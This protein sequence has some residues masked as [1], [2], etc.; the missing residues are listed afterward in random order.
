MPHLGRRSRHR[1]SHGT[2]GFQTQHT[3]FN[4]NSMV[5]TL[6]VPGRSNQQQSQRRLHQAVA[7]LSYQHFSRYHYPLYSQRWCLLLQGKGSGLYKLQHFH[8]IRTYLPVVAKAFIRP[9]PSHP[10]AL[11]TLLQF[12]PR[13]LSS[14]GRGPELTRR[15]RWQSWHQ[16][17]PSK[18]P[19]RRLA[20]SSSKQWLQVF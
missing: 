20:A 19:E 1:L 3:R 4:I 2:W 15:S 8:L 12:D 6:P 7:L 11:V 18:R 13:F 5:N 17:S 10:Y 16:R 9:D 14:H